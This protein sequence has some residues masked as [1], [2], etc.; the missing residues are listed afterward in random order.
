MTTNPKP[1]VGNDMVRIHKVITRALDVSLQ[2]I[3]SASPAE[4]PQQ[5]FATYVRAL[6]IL[7]HA[8]HA[9][10]DELAFPFWRIRLPAG[11]F[12]RLTEQ[13]RQM[14]SFIERIEGWL[15]AG[16][17]AWQSDALSELHHTL[18]DLQTLWQTHIT[19][20]ETTI[21]PDNSRQYL[22]PAENEQLAVQLAEHGQAHAQP[23]ELMMPF[24]IYNLSGADREEFVQ[25]LPPVIP[26]QLVPFAWKAAWSP[27]A[28]FLLEE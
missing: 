12:D 1:N 8:H 21:G 14:I 3:R 7:L 27:M 18:T 28:P 20:E 22:S 15:G 4:G 16:P 9:G 13:H 24:V 17:A 5:G 10:E 6:T 26:Q 23:G 25:L 2:H 19:L 11:P